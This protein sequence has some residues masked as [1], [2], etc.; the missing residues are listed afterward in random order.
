MFQFRAIVS[1]C[2]MCVDDSFFGRENV[3]IIF[4]NWTLYP[5]YALAAEKPAFNCSCMFVSCLSR[6]N[7]SAIRRGKRR[8]ASARQTHVLIKSQF[9]SIFAALVQV[10]F[11]RTINYAQNFGEIV[12]YEEKS[13]RLNCNVN[14]RRLGMPETSLIDKLWLWG[15]WFN[16]KIV[17]FW[18]QCATIEHCLFHMMNEARKTETF[19]IQFHYES[20]VQLILNLL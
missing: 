9:I 3:I 19:G 17:Q 7:S 13:V 8:W 2:V 16:L 4:R 11:R 6:G 1:V 5:F 10:S 18:E 20:I 12:K 14:G 15:G